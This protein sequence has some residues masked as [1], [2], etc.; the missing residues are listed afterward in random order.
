MKNCKKKRKLKIGIEP[1]GMGQTSGNFEKMIVKYNNATGHA[2]IGTL[3]VSEQILIKPEYRIYIELCENEELFWRLK[4]YEAVFIP[5]FGKN[6]FSCWWEN[7]RDYGNVKNII[8]ET[9]KVKTIFLKP[10]GTTLNKLREQIA[11]G[12]MAGMQEK[13]EII[14]SQFERLPV[15]LNKEL[16]QYDELE[17]FVYTN[18]KFTKERFSMDENFRQLENGDVIYLF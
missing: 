5:Y 10:T 2:N 6:E 8:S 16:K 18:M 11:F 15:G 3:N 13:V 12:L 14:F 4:N 17:E 9:F 7:F 1:I